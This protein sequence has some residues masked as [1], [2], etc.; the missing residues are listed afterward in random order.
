LEEV[1]VI[2]GRQIL[3]SI[4]G[5]ELRFQGGTFP[6]TS[7][8]EGKLSYRTVERV[9]NSLSQKNCVCVSLAKLW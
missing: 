2:E 5:R 8:E 1:L 6:T 7:E 9:E 3:S 4:Q